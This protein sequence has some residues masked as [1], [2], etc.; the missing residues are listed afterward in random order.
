MGLDNYWVRPGSE[1]IVYLDE[2]KELKL[3]GGLFS[4]HGNGSFRGKVYDN[5]IS[6]VTGVS[7]YEDR[8]ENERIKEM[9]DKLERIKWDDEF[10]EKYEITKQEFEDLKK[11]FRLYADAGCDLISWY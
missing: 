8:I 4:A 5:F 11:M 1:D 3:C 6:D 10:E 9:A 2:A 7:L